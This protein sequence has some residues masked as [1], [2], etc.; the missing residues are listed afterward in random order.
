MDVITLNAI[1]QVEN[2]IDVLDLVADDIL[3]NELKNY[4][5]VYCEVSNAC[6]YTSTSGQWATVFDIS[7]EGYLY[8]AVG[9]G[10]NL[11][12]SAGT[13]FWAKLTID[14]D[15]Y[16]YSGS[17]ATGSSSGANPAFGVNLITGQVGS[18]ANSI[19][20][21]GTIRPVGEY[22][23]EKVNGVFISG[24]SGAV[25][26]LS[27]PIFFATSAKFEC[28]LDANTTVTYTYNMRVK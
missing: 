3:D 5:T 7:G 28:F 16:Y 14:G 21:C 18:S 1:A 27:A 23:G 12:Y 6:S 22:Q 11:S 2:K 10:T 13:D 4:R 17:T 9:T 24:S 26:V 20:M 19:P 8:K 15:I 25:G